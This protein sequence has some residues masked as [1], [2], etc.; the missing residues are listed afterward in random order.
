V[1]LIILNKE[2][3]GEERRS[4]EH[5]LEELRILSET[6]G[7][8]EALAEKDLAFHRLLG[9]ASCNHMA[10]KVYDFV[11]GFIEPTIFKTHTI[12]KDGKMA[13]SVHK[14][15]VE[16]IQTSELAKARDAVYY[17]VQIWDTLRSGD[18]D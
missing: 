9:K 13:Y 6:G 7:S 11:L 1:E 8:I 18:E 2:R 15:I 3:N 12:Q 16:A 14:G 10:C 17:S 4:L 5:N